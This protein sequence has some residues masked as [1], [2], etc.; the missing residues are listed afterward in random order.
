LL[1]GL[2]GVTEALV[3]TPATSHDPYLDDGRPPPLVLQLR[4]AS[5]ERLEAAL[6]GAMADLAALPSLHGAEISE[7]AML[8]RGFPVPAADGEPAEGLP[9]TYL[10]AYDGVAADLNAWLSYYIRHHPP[11]MARFPGIRAI[12]ICTRLDWCSGSGWLREERMQRNKVVF[13]SPEALTAALNSPVRH[14]MRADFAKFPPFT[15]SN[16]HFPM[17]TRRIV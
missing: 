5:L 6:Q 12:E 13:A 1:Q 10:V 17:W 14:E 4:F 7:Q 9:C 8:T 2:E 16:T 11:I 15:G 3:F